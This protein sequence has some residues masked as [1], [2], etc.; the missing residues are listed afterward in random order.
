VSETRDLEFG[1]RERLAERIN[2]LT[3]ALQ[4]VDDGSYGV[5]ERCGRQIQPARLEAIPE[6]ACCRDCQEEI[7][8]GDR[9]ARPASL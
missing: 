5:C 2:R 6:A 9:T 4:R 3:A 1:N 7:E 8:R